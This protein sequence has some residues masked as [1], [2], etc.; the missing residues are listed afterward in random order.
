MCHP[1]DTLKPPQ[2]ILIQD[3]QVAQMPIHHPPRT[4]QKT[5][6]WISLRGKVPCHS[7]AH[8]V[9]DPQN[10]PQIKFLVMFF[11]LITANQRFSHDLVG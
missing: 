10:Y 6:T 9:Q 4:S 5:T 8:L 1:L 3:I 11:D 2:P 7:C